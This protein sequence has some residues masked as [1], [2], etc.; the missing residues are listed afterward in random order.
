MMMEMPQDQQRAGWTVGRSIAMEL[1]VAMTIIAGSM[2]TGKKSEEVYMAFMQDI[3]KI[4]LEELNTMIGKQKRWR[5]ILEQIAM[6]SGVITEGDYSRAT[7]TMRELNLATAFERMV[8]AA[9]HFNISPDLTLMPTQKLIDLTRRLRLALFEEVGIDF[10]QPSIHYYDRELEY[11]LQILQ[12]GEN[13]DRFWHWLDRFYYEAYRP[14]CSSRQSQLDTQQKQAITVLGAKEKSGS[15]PD[16]TWLSNKNLLLRFPRLKSS[17][18]SGLIKVHFWVEPFG[19][20]DS[21]SL[22]PGQLIIS[23]AEPGELYDDF[24]G[25]AR[26]VALRT[27]ALAD[28]TR[29]VILRLIR[30]VT[31]TNTDM[32]DYLGLARPTV[33]IHARILR[34]AGLIRSHQEG[35][36]MCH[37]IVPD[38]VRR[39]FRDLEHFLDLPD[40]N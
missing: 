25:F 10:N 38:E 23:F 19:F 16:I 1:D 34:E 9:A 15:V 39:L 26:D 2:V 12:G 6:L 30:N 13:H 27:H 33:S 29:L 8:A 11:C 31:M 3:P 22:L 4:W 28:P 32:A 35:R 5:S 37:E 18:T 24:I 21:W 36:I 20:A 7:M 17:V 40:E 14:W